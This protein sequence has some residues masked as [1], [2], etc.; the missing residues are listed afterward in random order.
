MLV[1]LGQ[2]FGIVFADDYE[3]FDA[4]AAPAFDVDAGFDADYVVFFDDIF[5][6]FAEVGA[7]VD[8]EADTVAKAVT[9]LV[10]VACFGDDVAGDSVNRFAYN[11][12]FCIT[13]GFEVSLEDD[14]VNLAEL[15]GSSPRIIVRV[16]SE[17]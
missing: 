12:C 13:L 17:W 7:F 9:E 10:A 1:G 2:D 5:R 16:M 3:I 14:V 8:F 11:A 4:D 15:V 6:E